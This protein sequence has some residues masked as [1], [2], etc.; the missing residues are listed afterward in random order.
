MSKGYIIWEGKSKIDGRPIVAIATMKTSNRKTGNMVQIWILDA[1]IDPVTSYKLGLDKSVCGSCTHRGID[2]KGRSCYVNLGQ[3]P[4]S[5]F[6]AYKRGVYPRVTD[7]LGKKWYQVKRFL[8]HLFQGAKIRFGAYGDPVL[9]P[10]WI[11]STI[12]DTAE[13]HTGYT[14]QWKRNQFQEYKPYFMASCDSMID[15]VIAK[16][17]GWRRFRVLTEESEKSEDSIECPS[18]SKNIQCAACTLCKGA[19]IAAKSIWIT[20]HGS[21]AKYVTT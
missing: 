20:A 4:L 10:L 3:A 21:G 5:I 2:G 6:K 12:V 16:N 8:T 14:H 13:S 15:E 7:L 1:E 17:H 9:I 11:V 19:S 18:D